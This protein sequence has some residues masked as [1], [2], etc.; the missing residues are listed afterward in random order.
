[1]RARELGIVIGR[2]PAG[3]A[4]AITDVAGVAVGHAN[5]EPDHTGVTT[6]LPGVD[7]DPWLEPYFVG[8]ARLNGA[9]EVA[10]LAQIEEWGIGETGI[11]LTGTPYVGAVYDA[12]TRLAMARQPLI[13]V[14]DV[15]IPIVAECDPSS[16]CD[17]RGGPP[18][19]LALVTRS[20]D[21][22]STGP[23]AEGQVGAGV[24]MH[25]FDW[26]G[27]IGTAS[28]RA[29]PYT[30][31]VLLLVN[32]GDAEDLRIDGDAVG[33]RVGAPPTRGGEGSCACVLATDA[34][35]LPQQL[36]RVARRI[37]LGLARTGSYGANGSGEVAV[38]FSTANRAALRRDQPGS[39]ASIEMLRN[40]A[41]NELFAAT[42]EASEEAVLNALFGA[43]TVN[44]PIGTT[45]AFD[46][47]RWRATAR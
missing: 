5:H 7:R 2:R 32:F 19:D 41:L 27:G 10:G 44:G 14:D 31:G 43:R 13:G 9:G 30:V 15:V 39:A 3:P 16:V 38:A 25:C 40:G 34:P 12:A 1:M 23:V 47:E 28:R 18:P 11:H 4:N 36:E 8:S 17:V 35:L 45:H 22:A 26:A 46:V 20:Y 37:F 29:G 33:A 21:E 24:G 42:V 6:V